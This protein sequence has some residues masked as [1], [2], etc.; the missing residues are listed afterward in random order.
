MTA[1]TRSDLAVICAELGRALLRIGK[2]LGAD[3]AREEAVQ[4]IGEAIAKAPGRPLTVSPEPAAAA[5]AA[6]GPA[7]AT[8]QQEA[9][10]AGPPQESQA[11]RILAFLAKGPSTAPE[12][13]EATNIQLGSC[14]AA[15]SG[16]VR[17]GAVDADNAHPRTYRLAG[18]PEPEAAELGPEAADEPRAE[19]SIIALPERA[20]P[21]SGPTL[22]E[23][24]LDLA[25]SGPFTIGMAASRLQR[26]TQ[27]CYNL[28]SDLCREGKLARSDYAPRVYG[29]PG[30]IPPVPAAEMPDYR[31][32][33]AAPLMRRCLRCEKKFQSDGAHNRLCG[34]CSS[35]VS[36][37]ALA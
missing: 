3:P 14:R 5:P 17:S 9:A 6:P 24:M 35:T 37:M 18:T 23:R 11:K 30:Q 7:P 25:A 31:A 26:S 4:E 28:L 32:P 19:T 27:H 1:L 21:K 29:L 13:A 33:S 15:L 22:R 12:I 8:P 16:L 20:A 2:Q 36:T 34:N 10:V